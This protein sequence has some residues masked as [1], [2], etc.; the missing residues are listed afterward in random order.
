LKRSSIIAS[1]FDF[2][3]K[4]TDRK[5]EQEEDISMLSPTLPRYGPSETAKLLMPS[6]LK[7][8]VRSSGISIRDLARGTGLSTRTVRAARNG[9]RIRKL[10]ALRIEKVLRE[11]E[12]E[13]LD[14]EELG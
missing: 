8:R 14:K 12:M 1:G 11:H 13:E 7:T 10:T 4:E 3:G 9:K 6:I 2:I 5:W